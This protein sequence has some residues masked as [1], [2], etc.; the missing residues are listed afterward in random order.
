[1]KNQMIL[2]SLITLAAFLL[3]S[4]GDTD[5]DGAPAGAVDEDQK[6]D[7]SLAGLQQF[8]P[9]HDQIDGLTGANEYRQF[10]G[11]TL[12]EYMNG[13][14]E[15]YLALGFV[16]IGTREY[17]TTLAEDIFLTIEIYDM[18]LGPNAQKI[19]QKNNAANTEPAGVGEESSLGG[20]TIEFW[21]A[22]YLVRVRC[23]DVGAEVDRLLKE[24]AHFVEKALEQ[25]E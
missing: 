15:I 12:F 24:T 11:Q 10:D 1:M 21:T 23:D 7:R 6:T 16:A 13:G 3:V 9:S 5:G 2:L 22:Q 18:A 17:T 14:A 20:G 4:C 25:A 8:F 19:F